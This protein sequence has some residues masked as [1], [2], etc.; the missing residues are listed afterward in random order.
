[1]RT[2]RAFTVTPGP[3][4]IEMLEKHAVETIRDA[5]EYSEQYLD[6]L[7]TAITVMRHP[8]PWFHWKDDDGVEWTRHFDSISAGLH[9]RAEEPPPK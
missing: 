4:I 6:G 7:V 3:S 2:D 1:M 9:A 8:Y 5:D